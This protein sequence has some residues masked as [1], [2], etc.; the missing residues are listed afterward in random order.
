MPLS[1]TNTPTFYTAMIT[2]FK[3]DW[4]QLYKGIY[5]DPKLLPCGNQEVIS[6]TFILDDL[7]IWLD[8]VAMLLNLF[9]CVCW[10]FNKYCCSFKLNKG[11]F[12]QLQ[13][14]YVERDITKDGNSPVSLKYQT[15]LDWGVHLI[16]ESI[17][18]FIGLMVFYIKFVPWQEV[19]FIILRKL[20]L[21]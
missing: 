17:C 19:N 8:G 3:F 14:E 6:S 21:F 10:V 15:I 11:E 5:C 4:I 13:Y 2:Y 16:E 20:F 7:L 18:S 1:P 9:S 12:L